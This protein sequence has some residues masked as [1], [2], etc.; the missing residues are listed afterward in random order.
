MIK[1]SIAE[2]Q[3]IIMVKINS[4]N[5]NNDVKDIEKIKINIS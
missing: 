3:R 4:D 2:N 5:N 1:K